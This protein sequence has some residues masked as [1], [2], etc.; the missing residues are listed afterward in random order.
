MIRDAVIRNFEIIGEAAGR[1]SPATRGGDAVPWGADH[2]VPKSA[3]PW[4][5]GRRPVLVWDVI[6]PNLIVS[7]TLLFFSNTSIPNRE[8]TSTPLPIDRFNFAH[9]KEFYAAIDL[10]EI[11]NISHLCR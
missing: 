10:D 9:F 7:A 6:Q 3:H 5:L 8:T 1:L 11:G 2:R 4:V